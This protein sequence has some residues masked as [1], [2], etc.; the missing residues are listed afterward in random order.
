MTVAPERPRR[1][2]SGDAVKQC[3]A[4]RSFNVRRS[5]FTNGKAKSKSFQSPYRCNACDTSFW[6]F[7]R[8]TR[9]V[10]ITGIAASA[11]VVLVGILS[12]VG[13]RAIQHHPPAN[14]STATTTLAPDDA[15][16]VTR[17]SVFDPH[18]PIPVAS[19]NPSR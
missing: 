4:C 8:T 10:G 13:A 18:A 5:G 15:Q 9:I 16:S 12:T 19:A 14:E 3:P 2:P 17:G 11:F 7:S 6:V 1:I